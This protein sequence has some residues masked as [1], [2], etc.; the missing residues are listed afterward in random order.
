MITLKT[1]TEKEIQKNFGK[2]IKVGLQLL[3]YLFEQ[4]LI[5]IKD[6]QNVCALSP[7]A[8]GDLVKLF[9]SSGLLKEFTGNFRN[10]L[11]VFDKYLTLFE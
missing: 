6:V 4:P 10:R 1:N 8:A 5:S 9:Q 3:N 2:R 7:K 11:F